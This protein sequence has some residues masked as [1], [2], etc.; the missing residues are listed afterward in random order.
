MVGIIQNNNNINII[1]KIN[2]FNI[3]IIKF[4]NRNIDYSYKI[5]KNKNIKLYFSKNLKNKFIVILYII[6]NK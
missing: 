5:L 4:L 2:Y 3:I 1:L 6:K